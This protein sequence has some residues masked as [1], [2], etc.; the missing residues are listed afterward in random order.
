MLNISKEIL[1]IGKEGSCISVEY[2]YMSYCTDE[3]I[4]GKQCIIAKDTL[5]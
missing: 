2:G 1:T 5:K 4:Y 3:C